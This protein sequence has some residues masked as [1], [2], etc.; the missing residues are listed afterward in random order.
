MWCG[1]CMW[2]TEKKRGILKKRA[3]FSGI[4]EDYKLLKVLGFSRET[5]SKR[6]FV[7]PPIHP[8][9]Y[10]FSCLFNE[11]AHNSVENWWVQNLKGVVAGWWFREEQTSNLLAEFLV[12]QGRSVFIRFS[13]STDWMILLTLQGTICHTQCPSV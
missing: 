11:L 1:V 7:Q 3:C 4:L 8:P 5:G 9:T 10:L 12:A 6:L 2:E 13:P